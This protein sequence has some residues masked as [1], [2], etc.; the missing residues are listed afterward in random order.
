MKCDWELKT[1]MLPADWSTGIVYNGGTSLPRPDA[2]DDPNALL[3]MEMDGGLNSQQ[4]WLSSA[5]PT[6]V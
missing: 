6:L 2:Y 1:S 5:L 4:N 3:V